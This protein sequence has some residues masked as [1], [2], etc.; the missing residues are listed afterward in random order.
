MIIKFVTDSTSDIPAELARQL[1]I[2]VVPALLNIGQASLLDG[3]DISRS[4]FYHQLPEMMPPPT[5]SSP[6]VGQFQACY[7]QLLS[8][9]T[10]RIISVHPPNHL[11][12]IFNAA[13]LAAEN[14]KGRVQVEDSG[15]VSLGMGF[16]V[17]AAA[18]ASRGGASLE[19]VRALLASI[20]KRVRL[21]A[22][23]DSIKYLRRSGR[24]SWAAATIGGL[25]HLKPIVELRHGI[26]H[27]LGQARTR[28]QGV[29]RLRETLNSW[30]PIERLAVLHTNAEERAR[31][32]LDLVI[33]KTAI[34]PLVVNVTT[35]IGVHVGPD[36][37][38]FVAVP[39]AS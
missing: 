31:A 20:R 38:G 9:G 19:N 26:V 36:G 23:L 37:L 10:D 18:E 25:L 32:L 30:G 28:M 8:K 12:A 29:E 21:A 34:S 33:L 6:S 4:D 16:Q 11:S 15:Q 22:L 14:F 35:V 39:A 5:T 7:E 24:V 27:R 2:T 3:V 1:D 17:L 13:R